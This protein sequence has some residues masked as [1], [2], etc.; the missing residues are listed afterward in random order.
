MYRS[1]VSYAQANS[2]EVTGVTVLDLARVRRLPQ[3]QSALTRAAVARGQ[4]LAIMESR[5]TKSTFEFEEACD[6]AKVPYQV[7]EENADP[8]T[9]LVDLARYHD[10]IVFGLRSI[11]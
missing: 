1:Y 4:R 11:F 7:V 9:K 10:L 5:I 2:A 6:G 3:V 8:F